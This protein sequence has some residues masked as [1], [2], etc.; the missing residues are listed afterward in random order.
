MVFLHG[1]FEKLFFMIDVLAIIF[2]ILLWGLITFVLFKLKKIKNYIK[3]SS[4]SKKA[5]VILIALLL[6]S[7]IFFGS[8]LILGT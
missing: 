6:T 3:D 7:I 8:M 1:N 2:F 4:N 5:F